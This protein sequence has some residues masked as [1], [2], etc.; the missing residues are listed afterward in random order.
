MAFSIL[1][2]WLFVCEWCAAGVKHL[3]LTTVHLLAQNLL[4][5]W[6]FLLV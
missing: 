1:L 4:M 5:N 2:A 3:K 6:D